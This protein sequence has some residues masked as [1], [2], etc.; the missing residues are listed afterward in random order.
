VLDLLETST[1]PSPADLANEAIRR[2][3]AAQ[4]TWSPAELAELDRLR[5]VWARAVRDAAGR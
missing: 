1:E 2:F 3:V 4:R 5:G